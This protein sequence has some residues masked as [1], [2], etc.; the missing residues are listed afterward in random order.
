[1]GPRELSF[2]LFVTVDA[3]GSPKQ[4]AQGT[5]LGRFLWDETGGSVTG[6][7]RSLVV[8]RPYADRLARVDF[9]PSN[10]AILSLPL[11]GGEKIRWLV[12]GR[13]K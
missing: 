10:R 2:N 5:S 8:F 3:N 11:I 1:M 7:E 6:T 12:D 9:D 4:I 13:G